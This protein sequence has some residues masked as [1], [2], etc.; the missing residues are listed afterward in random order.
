MWKTGD[1]FKDIVDDYSISEQRMEGNDY[2]CRSRR[3]A[4]FWIMLLPQI[5]GFVCGLA[6]ARLFHLDGSAYI[7]IGAMV[8]LISGTYRSGSYDKI[9][10]VPAIVRNIILMLIFCAMLWLA[11]IGK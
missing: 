11:G 2:G 5:I 6:F 4:S 3:G 10:L 7:P 9:S 1:I 8:A